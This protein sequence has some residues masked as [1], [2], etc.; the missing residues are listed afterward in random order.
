MSFK[1]QDHECSDCGH[2]TEILLDS[3]NPEQVLECGKCK[4][5]NVKPI[6]SVGQGKGPHVSW[7]SWRA[8]LK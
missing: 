1:I 6:V 2:V 3:Q 4:S 8:D 5:V 7:S